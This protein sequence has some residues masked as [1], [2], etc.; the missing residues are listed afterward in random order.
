M[1]ARYTDQ[2]LHEVMADL[3][4]RLAG[5]ETVEFEVP[6]PD[7]SAGHFTGEFVDG[8]RHR[9]LAVWVRLAEQLGCA[10]T[11]PRPLEDGFVRLGLRPLDDE[12]SW[13]RT[14][15]ASG[16]PEKYGAQSVFARI[17]KF[18]QPDFLVAFRRA[19]AFVDPPA[20]ARVLAVGCNQGDELA[21]VRRVRPEAQLVGLDHS[22]SAIERGRTRVPDADLRVVDL[23][24]FDALT[25]GRFDLVL[26]INVLHSPGLDGQA[27]CRRVVTRHLTPSGGL[28][29]GLPNSRYVGTG[30][31][32]GASVKN[33]AHAELSVLVRDAAFYK[34]Y[35]ARHLFRVT[36]TGQ[37]TL[38]VTAKALPDRVRRQQAQ[39]D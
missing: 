17:D 15:G 21:M 22:A 28:V 7:R 5:G 12:A 31:R 2:P 6:D 25:L 14:A 18:E 16:A 37:H 29:I 39:L 36:L 26:A 13:H 19:V 24:D 1:P 23:N 32:Y 38:L 10:M 35:L 8:V 20:S 4:A 34:R 11:T 9:S 30:L 3:E 33:H 27:L